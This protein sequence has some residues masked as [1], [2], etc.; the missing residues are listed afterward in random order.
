M[1]RFVFLILFFITLNGYTQIQTPKSI[2]KEVITT[3]E[4]YPELQDVN[5]EIKFKKNI[6]KSTMQAQPKF[7][8]F[9]KS[10]KNREY[11]IF[12]SEKFKISD[13][14]FSTKD[15]PSKILVGWLGHEFGHIM[16]YQQRSNMNMIG[17]G[18]KYLFSDNY[19][20]E[21]ERTADTYAVAHGMESYILKTKNFI[22]NNS[23]ITP[24]YKQRIKKYYLS[25][26]EIMDMVNQRDDDMSESASTQH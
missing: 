18:I 21:A 7:N 25:P 12:I 2:E 5:I 1:K 10:K 17:F 26:E 4:F 3:L 11:V 8:S 22:L 19:I 24:S 9:F 6:K 16:D 13:K 15:I 14:N 23:E 20:I